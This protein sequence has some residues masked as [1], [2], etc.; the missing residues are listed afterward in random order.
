MLHAFSGPFVMWSVVSWPCGQA[1]H[2]AGPRLGR[3]SV[4]GGLLDVVFT[5]SYYPLCG[6]SQHQH[7][8]ARCCS[9]QWGS[10][11]WLIAAC[12]S[13]LQWPS[14]PRP[15][16]IMGGSIVVA[17]RMLFATTTNKVFEPPPKRR[18]P[19]VRWLWYKRCRKESEKH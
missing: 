11:G 9:T 12:C 16:F 15:L 7:S 1:W 18:M 8:A 17:T 10:V 13:M 6:L 14:P 19:Q 5:P 2:F 3:I 4:S